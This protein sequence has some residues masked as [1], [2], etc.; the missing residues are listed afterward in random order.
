MV[1]KS[2][3]MS[4]LDKSFEKVLKDPEKYEAEYY[5]LFLNSVIYVP[6]WDIPEEEKTRVLEEEESIKPVI[7]DVEGKK[8]IPIFD[9]KERLSEWAQGQDIGIAGLSG[10]DVISLLGSDFYLML[11][12]NSEHLKEFSP[13]EVKWLLSVTGQ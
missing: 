9:S 8:T 12:V 5:E 10:F 4:E 1:A 13:E 7:I 11:N 2:L 6:T 3:F